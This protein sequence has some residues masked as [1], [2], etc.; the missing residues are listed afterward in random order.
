[1]LYHHLTALRGLC[2]HIPDFSS[3]RCQAFD[4]ISGLPIAHFRTDS[5]QPLFQGE[6][7]CEV[8]VM[9]IYGYMVISVFFHIESGTNFHNKDF[10]LKALREGLPEWPSTSEMH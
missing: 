6:S 7:T 2:L 5:L 4:F 9:D 10:L 3:H 1:M 8:V